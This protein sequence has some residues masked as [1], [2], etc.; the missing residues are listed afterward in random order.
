MEIANIPDYI[1]Y[2]NG[3]VFSKD[4]VIERSNGKKQ[5]YKSQLMKPHLAANGYLRICL[6][7]DKKQTHYLVHRLIAQAYIPN[8]DNLP[9]VNHIDTNRSNN[10][11]ENLEWC[12][13]QYNN[14][15]INTNKN[16]GYI[17]KTPSNTHQ[18]KY[19]TNGI[20]HYKNFKKE[21]DAIVHLVMEEM[22][23][24]LEAQL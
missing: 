17:W 21:S 19:T 7:V 11:I 4:R 18:T 23:A 13:Q 5:F 16:F 8:P 2:K 6:S 1:I 20:T 9:C 22:I 3:D 12:T 15:S 10:S 14:Q 24:K